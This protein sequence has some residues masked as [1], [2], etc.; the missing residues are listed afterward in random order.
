MRQVDGKELKP[1]DLAR[2]H[3]YRVSVSCKTA[4]LPGEEG[5]VSYATYPEI[6]ADIIANGS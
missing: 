5:E 1:R 3:E 4:P 2:D 6:T